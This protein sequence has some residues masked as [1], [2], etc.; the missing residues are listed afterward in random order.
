VVLSVLSEVMVLLEREVQ[1]KQAKICNTLLVGGLDRIALNVFLEK[2][3]GRQPA[4]WKNHILQRAKEAMSQVQSF[5]IP[6]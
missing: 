3:V 6:P 5:S 4:G 1:I 2:S